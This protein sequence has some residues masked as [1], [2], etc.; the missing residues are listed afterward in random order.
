MA[1]STEFHTNNP[2]SE[3]D[4]LAKFNEFD[5]LPDRNRDKRL[6]A[7]QGL[8][9]DPQFKQS[10]G[11]VT[12]GVLCWQVACDLQAISQ[13][14]MEALGCFHGNWKPEYNHP[15]E[16]CLI[17]KATSLAEEAKANFKQF[18]GIQQ[19]EKQKVKHS[20]RVQ[21]RRYESDCIEAIR[22][23]DLEIEKTDD[24][25]NLLKKRVEQ[26]Q[27]WRMT[28]TKAGALT[29]SQR[30]TLTQFE[31]CLEKLEE[32]TD[33]H[34][35]LAHGLRRL[36]RKADKDLLALSSNRSEYGVCLW[37]LALKLEDVAIKGAD[38]DFKDEY[39][40]LEQAKHGFE[41]A[42]HC[43]TF[44]EYKE[45]CEAKAKETNVRMEKLRA[46]IDEQEVYEKS[47]FEECDI[48]LAEPKKLVAS[49]SSALIEKDKTEVK[50]QKMQCDPVLIL[51]EIENTQS[52]PIFLPT[53]SL[54]PQEI[55]ISVSAYIVTTDDR[56]LFNP[57]VRSHDVHIKMPTTQQ[58]QGKVVKP[59][60]GRPTKKKN[61][62]KV[63]CDFSLTTHSGAFPTS[64]K[65]SISQ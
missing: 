11:N 64:I 41:L 33:D 40:Y 17:E 54:A 57:R 27:Q 25:V 39:P 37:N 16:L 44:P 28:I 8:K 5:Q 6:A 53:A 12:F 51:P 56:S 45:N 43:Y 22:K 42:Q 1:A 14:S 30:A 46:M 3:A 61:P 34:H 7:L 62:Q 21:D 15:N 26:V 50:Q 36:I 24:L 18:L 49:I 23:C 59:R 13:D 58:K 63:A 60:R 48:E 31:H 52:K 20:T 9:A 38:D 47:S 19:N 55:Q 29:R 4:Y 2:L 10:V 35:A 32:I 65:V